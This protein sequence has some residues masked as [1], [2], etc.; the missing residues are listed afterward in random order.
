MNDIRNI[1]LEK[2]K[3]KVSS[4]ASFTLSCL[5]EETHQTIIVFKCSYTT[6]SHRQYNISN[7]SCPKKTKAQAPFCSSHQCYKNIL[8]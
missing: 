1:L 5:K 7:K 6:L 2:E 4:C 8:A 3:Y